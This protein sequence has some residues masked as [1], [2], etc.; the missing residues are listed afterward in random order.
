MER[1]R[2]T[3]LQVAIVIVAAAAATSIWH[4][5]VASEK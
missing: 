4:M 2:W 5:K 1:K 3:S